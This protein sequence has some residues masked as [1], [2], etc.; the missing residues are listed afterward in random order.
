MN[1]SKRLL[2]CPACHGMNRV[3][4]SKLSN[5]PNCGHCGSPLFS[6]RPVDL[7]TKG[8]N[9][10]GRRADLPMLVDFWADWCGPC[11]M[12][13]PALAEATKQLEPYVRVG[14]VDTE[15]EQALAAEFGIRSIPTLIVVEHGREIAR[16]A[17]AMPAS[18][19]VQ[20]VKQATR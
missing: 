12:M 20:F 15:A 18:A 8:F 6:G 17:G 1:D 9:N 19:I 5:H 4:D 16:Q 7:N 14:K 2:A 10:H 11:K 3:S 13:A